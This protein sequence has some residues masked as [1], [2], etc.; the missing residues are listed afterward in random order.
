[1]DYP[2]GRVATAHGASDATSFAAQQLQAVSLQQLGNQVRIASERRVLEC[3]RGDPST[4][5]YLAARTC[6][7]WKASRF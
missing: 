1:M 3:Q 5:K 2:G 7:A 6:N 4:S